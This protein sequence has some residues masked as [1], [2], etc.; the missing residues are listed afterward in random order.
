MTVQTT[1]HVLTL[2]PERAS[3]VWARGV[4]FE[5]DLDAEAARGWLLAMSPLVCGPS[6]CVRAEDLRA[7]TS[8][9]APILFRYG[10]SSAAVLPTRPIDVLRALASAIEVSGRP[11][12]V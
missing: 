10:G 12:P 1:S 2:A 6:E 4:L 3:A 7:A 5:L 11:Q 9:T 8:A